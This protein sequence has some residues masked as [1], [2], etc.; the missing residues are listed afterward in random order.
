MSASMWDLGGLPAGQ[1]AKRVWS[2]ANQD[3]VWG[4][5]A[6]LSFYFLLAM[7]PALI[8]LLALLG[9]LAEASSSLRTGLTDYLSQALPG[10]AGAL[11]TRTL[12][13]I[14]S[15]ASG[16]IL[17]FGV[18]VALWTA[19]SGMAAMIKTLNIAYE[20]EESRP[21]WKQRLVAIGLTVA[22]SVLLL[23]GLALVVVR[24]VPR[25]V[26]PLVALVDEELE[27]WI[28]AGVRHGCSLLLPGG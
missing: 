27:L 11:V 8:F 3:D 26:A 12:D 25:H 10:E 18:V 16:G 21:W 15:Q 7:F 9:L 5:G 13:Q 2:K 22:L 19:S 14:S 6:E 24:Q 17:S 1:L 28:Y 23:I 20:I 4:R